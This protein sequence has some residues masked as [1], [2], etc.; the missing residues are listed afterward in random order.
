MSKIYKSAMGRIVDVDALRLANEGTIAV[1]NMQTNARGDEL[2]SGG[3]IVKTRAQVM[4]EYHKL[5]TPLIND[6]PVE[7]EQSNHKPTGKLKTP[8]VNDTPIF[9]SVESVL[10]QYSGTDSEST[11]Q[12]DDDDNDFVDQLETDNEE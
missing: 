1:G 2:G 6:I 4:S 9:E 11:I 7:H 12:A 8:M 5:N 3:E 10:A